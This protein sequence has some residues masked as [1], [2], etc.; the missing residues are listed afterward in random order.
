MAHLGNH[1][2][3][4]NWVDQSFPQACD[5]APEES[6]RT[7]TVLACIHCGAPDCSCI[8]QLVKHCLEI[9][10]RH[11]NV[12]NN[13]VSHLSQ[14]PGIVFNLSHLPVCFSW[15]WFNKYAASFCFVEE[16]PGNLRPVRINSKTPL[17]FQPISTNLSRKLSRWSRQFDQQSGSQCA[18]LVQHPRC[19]APSVS[20]SHEEIP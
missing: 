19:S 13:S 5:L 12:L 14:V 11:I 4:P 15:C 1:P 20:S 3:D 2:Q 7:P 6:N 16:T 18:Y 17:D 9:T 8:R 10:L